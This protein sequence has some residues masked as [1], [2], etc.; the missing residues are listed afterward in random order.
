MG[1]KRGKQREHA[2]KEAEERCERLRDALRFRRMSMIEFCVAE[3]V[4]SGSVRKWIERGDDTLRE[5]MIGNA[6]TTERF[7][8]AL[9]VPVDTLTVGGPTLWM[10]Q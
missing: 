6:V 9:R 3:R 7:A 8:K 10:F 2:S 5:P 1:G 4:S